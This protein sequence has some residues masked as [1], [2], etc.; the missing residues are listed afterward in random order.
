MSTRRAERDKP[1]LSGLVLHALVETS[2]EQRLGIIPREP[3]FNLVFANFTHSIGRRPS[4][5][6][7][8]LRELST[9]RPSL[10]AGRGHEVPALSADVIARDELLHRIGHLGRH[11]KH[12][13]ELSLQ[14]IADPRSDGLKTF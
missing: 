1:I 6:T 3:R 2:P 13:C 11:S 14:L 9:L 8:V 12:M 5:E 7:T 4:I 10:T